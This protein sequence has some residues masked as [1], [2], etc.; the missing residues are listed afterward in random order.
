MFRSEQLV[1]IAILLLQLARVVGLLHGLW[2]IVGQCLHGVDQVD[3]F[4]P[5]IYI[6]VES[7]Y[8]IDDISMLEFGSTGEPGQ[9]HP[10]IVRVDLAMSVLVNHPENRQDRIV[11]TGHQLLLE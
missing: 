10:E 8:P 1:L 5:A 3:E 6:L 4:K 9:E 7:S 11:E 2:L